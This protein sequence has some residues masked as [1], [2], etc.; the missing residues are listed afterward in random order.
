M[1]RDAR[2]HARSVVK[3]LILGNERSHEER[4]C[5][6]LEILGGD[7]LKE[8]PCILQKMFTTEKIF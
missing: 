4:T 6:H 3:K 2:Y 7:K 8:T 5:W 1:Q